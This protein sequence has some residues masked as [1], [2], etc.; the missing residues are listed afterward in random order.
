MY[1][2]IYNLVIK[3]DDLPLK[4]RLGILGIKM[5]ARAPALGEYI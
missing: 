5:R 1:V 3:Q 2:E 4:S